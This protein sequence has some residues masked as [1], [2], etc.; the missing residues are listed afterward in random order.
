MET[1]ELQASHAAAAASLWLLG[2]R[3]NAIADESFAPRMSASQFAAV[4]AE[5]LASRTLFG[6]GIVSGSEQGLAGYLTAEV[7][8]AAPEL[9][10]GRYLYLLDLDVSRDE[11]RK[12]LGTR[13]VEAARRHAELSGLSRVEVS[14]VSADA[15]AAAFWHRQ[16]FKQ[17]L[18]RARVDIPS[19]H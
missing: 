9:G 14:W 18:S 15:Q 5:Q 13:L 10:S 4:L 12:G 6:W 2:M 7:K 8:E 11:R 19:T 16:G 1:V 3:E 17:Y